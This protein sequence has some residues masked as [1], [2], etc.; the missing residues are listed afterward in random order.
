MINFARRN[1]SDIGRTDGKGYRFCEPHPAFTSAGRRGYRSLPDGV[2]R[3]PLLLAIS[4]AG[5]PVAISIIVAGFLAQKDYANVRQVFRV[6]L[7]L[8][9]CVG[10]VLAVC[11]VLAAGWLVDAGVIT[12]A[13][14]YYSLIALTPAIF[15]ATILASFRGYFRDIS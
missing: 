11:L 1:D 4:A 2:S 12:D 10:A 7:C 9:A 14:A 5:I 13:R 8:M 15:F 3:I 6:S